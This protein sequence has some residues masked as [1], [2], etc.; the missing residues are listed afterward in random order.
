MT[1]AAGEGRNEWAQN[2]PLRGYSTRQR[3]PPQAPKGPE[4]HSE[5]QRHGWTHPDR[6]DPPG[7]RAPTTAAAQNAIV[8]PRRRFGSN[9]EASPAQLRLNGR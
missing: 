1:L 3:K 5:G 7:Q 9:R 8:N 4:H 6:R 2:Q